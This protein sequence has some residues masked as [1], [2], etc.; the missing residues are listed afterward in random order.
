MSLTG[1]RTAGRSDGRVR[2]PDPSRLTASEGAGSSTSGAADA[3]A[4]CRTPHHVGVLQPDRRFTTAQ[5]VAAGVTRAQLRGPA[6]VQVIH[7]VHA[8]ALAMAA[9]LRALTRVRAALL[10]HPPGAVA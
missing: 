10:T 8:P 7:G 6:Y 2:G 3:A 9:S 4:G 5:A 1:A